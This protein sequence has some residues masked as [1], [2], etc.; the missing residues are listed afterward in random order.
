MESVMRLI[1]RT[2]RYFSLYRSEQLEK[3]GLTGIQHH[4]IL[5]ICDTPGITQEQLAEGLSINKSNVARQLAQMERKGFVTRI[6]SET[7]R[8]RLHVYPTTRA[9]KLYPKIKQIHR[10][11]NER[12]LEGFSEEERKDLYSKMERIM[13]RAALLLEEERRPKYAAG[14]EEQPP[15]E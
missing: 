9:E 12:L 11:W 1:S 3:E 10:Y 6:P 14:K 13:N 8:R 4:Y 15:C 5:R 2:F 7:D